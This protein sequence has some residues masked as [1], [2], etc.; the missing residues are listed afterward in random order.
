MAMLA[1]ESDSLR[2]NRLDVDPGRY[3]HDQ[4]LYMMIVCKAQ[5]KF[6]SYDKTGL[7][8]G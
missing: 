2:Y 7:E 5:G 6:G 4:N 3:C 8:A 1:N